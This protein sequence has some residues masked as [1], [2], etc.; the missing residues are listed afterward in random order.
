MHLL[1]AFL[2]LQN[3]AISGTVKNEEGKSLASVRVAAMP[4]GGD[5]AIGTVYTDKDGHYTLQLPPGDYYV[6]A[7]NILWPTYYAPNGLRVAIS[8]S[9][10]RVDFLLNTPNSRPF[11]QREQWLP[12]LPL[13]WD[14]P[15]T[16]P[17]LLWPR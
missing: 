17:K 16:P 9:Q 13:Q 14:V 8:T 10:D 2:L 4:V 15:P 1:V 3:V 6:V 7:G 12:K 5:S 11:L